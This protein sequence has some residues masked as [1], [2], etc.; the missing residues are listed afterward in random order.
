[1]R[2]ANQFRTDVDSFHHVAKTRKVFAQPSG[3]AAAIE[4]LTARGQRQSDGDVREVTEMTKRFRVHAF[5]GMVRWFVRQVVKRLGKKIM[6]MLGVELVDIIDRGLA[7]VDALQFSQPTVDVI[8]SGRRWRG[9]KRSN[10][11]WLS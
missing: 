2:N 7:I 8:G 9:Q 6:P 5:A 3:A 4:N 10:R 1:M 11:G